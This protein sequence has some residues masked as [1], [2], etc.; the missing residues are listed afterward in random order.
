MGCRH[1]YG[2][3]WR[4]IAHSVYYHVL[5][6]HAVG[7]RPW[8]WHERNSNGFF[9]K[10]IRFQSKASVVFSVTSRIYWFLLNKLNGFSQQKTNEYLNSAEQITRNGIVNLVSVLITSWDYT[11]CCSINQLWKALMEHMSEHTGLISS[12]QLIISGACS[13][14]GGKMKGSH[15]GAA[16]RCQFVPRYS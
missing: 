10:Q 3:L 12:Y 8:I 7:G 14:T 5:L 15:P 11:K 2:Y 9:I 13:Y 1:V 16:D 6:Q 4:P